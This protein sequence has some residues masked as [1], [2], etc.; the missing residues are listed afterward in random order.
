MTTTRYSRETKHYDRKVLTHL[1]ET[2]QGRFYPVQGGI[3]VIKTE[4]G[5][6]AVRPHQ[7]ID[8]P[9]TRVVEDVVEV[10]VVSPMDG[11]HGQERYD[12]EDVGPGGVVYDSLLALAERRVALGGVDSDPLVLVRQMLDDESGDLEREVRAEVEPGTAKSRPSARGRSRVMSPSEED[13]LLAHF[14]V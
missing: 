3:Y 6:V 4:D 13:D 2:G 9:V 10:R 12:G 5:T 8:L 11:Y 7:V 14:G 1:V